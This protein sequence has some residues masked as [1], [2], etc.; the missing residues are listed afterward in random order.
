MGARKEKSKKL[1]RI[2]GDR[3]GK[4]GAAVMAVQLVKL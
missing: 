1:R 2:F 4:C 3:R